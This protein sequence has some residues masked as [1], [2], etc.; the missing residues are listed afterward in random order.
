MLA[1]SETNRSHFLLG[2]ARLAAVSSKIN[3]RATGEP[4]SNS[5]MSFPS[6]LTVELSR[7]D[8]SVHGLPPFS[9]YILEIIAL[10]SN[11]KN[12]NISITAFSTLASGHLLSHM[13]HKPPMGPGDGHNMG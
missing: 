12:Y 9:A 13:S 10:R 7:Q 6:T 1:S 8:E 3:I 5:E 2:L 4:D 11:Q